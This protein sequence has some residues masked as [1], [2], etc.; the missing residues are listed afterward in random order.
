MSRPMLAAVAALFAAA[1]TAADKIDNPMYKN[2]A[3]FK[4]DTSVTMKTTIDAGGNAI[5]TVT[6]TK[7]IE[8]RDDKV[9]VEVQTT[10]KFM[11]METKQPATKQ[12]IPKQVD[13]GTAPAADPKAVKPEGK[14]EDGTKKVKVGGTEFE[15]K[16]V[17]YTG[18]DVES[19]TVTSDDVPG[20]MVK[21]TSKAKAGGTTMEVTEV[22]IKK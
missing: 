10:S 20:M 11:G 17:K 16:W 2:W 9:V 22:T 19:E 4:P 15:C 7:L 8:V 1:A 13:G 14:T 5:E 3:K 12:D 6:T 21:M 18:K